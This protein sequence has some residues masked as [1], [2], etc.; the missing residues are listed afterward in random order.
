MQYDLD[1]SSNMA[2]SQAAVSSTTPP[3]S[4][5]QTPGMHARADTAPSHMIFPGRGLFF[6]FKGIVP[7]NAAQAYPKKGFADRSHSPSTVLA[8]ATQRLAHEN[9]VHR[10]KNP[11]EPRTNR[12]DSGMN[13]TGL[14]VPGVR[15][16]SRDP[17]CA[18]GAANC[19]KSAATPRA[20]NIVFA[21]TS[22]K[23]PRRRR[24][25]FMINA[26]SLRC[27]CRRFI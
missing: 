1:D 10:G 4:G 9:R 5:P 6:C 21:R 16:R 18:N 20:V 24:W 8:K 12:I 2:V 22:A 11:R 3:R 23:L 17:S 26:L 14:A 27:Q 15:Q 7:Q 13:R 19:R 25:K